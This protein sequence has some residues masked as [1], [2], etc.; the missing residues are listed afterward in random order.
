M[1]EVASWR[2]IATLPS[3]P[4]PSDAGLLPSSF[5]LLP[6]A[7]K[8][9]LH[10]GVNIDHVATVRQ[11]RRT[12]EP[13]PI[14]AAVLAELGGADGIT[15]HLRQDR[16][17]IQDRDLKLLRQTLRG[18]LNLEMAPHEESGILALALQLVPDQVCLVPEHRQEV[19][20]EGGLLIRTDDLR[21]RQTID[22]LKAKRILVSLFIEPDPD[23]VRLAHALGADAIELHTGSWANA[24]ALCKGRSEDA[25]L[26]HELSRLETAAEAAAAL[27]VRLHAGHGITY[28]NVGDL[29]HLPLLR[30]LNI[31]HCI[32]SRALMVGMERA[33]RDMKDLLR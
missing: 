1:R 15:V 33:V 19:T 14:A 6:S 11:A 7:F 32:V 27:G 17:H 5:C 4:D 24:W 9:M 22:Q 10:L 30:E 31:G 23:T 29:L 8:I 18:R 16:R 2:G 13:D 26:R 25:S 12:V 3:L 21:L 28:S 20:T